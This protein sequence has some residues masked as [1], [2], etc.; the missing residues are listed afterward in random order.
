MA[1]LNYN[2]KLV[3]NLFINYFNLNF[4]LK[5]KNLKKITF[6][7]KIKEIYKTIFNVY[8]L[9]RKSYI[10]T[11]N[12]IYLYKLNLIKNMIFSN[13]SYK[14]FTSK[15]KFRYYKYIGKKLT[16]IKRFRNRSFNNII[17]SLPYI[18]YALNKVTIILYVY[19]R[20][21]IY[22]INK[23]HKLNKIFLHLS[24]KNILNNKV[25]LK[26]L[27]LFK[28]QH[29]KFIDR[30][31][32]N[33]IVSKFLIKKI[34]NK[35]I[36]NNLFKLKNYF[37]MLFLY[38]NNNIIKNIN[39]N[40]YII[41]SLKKIMNKNLKKVFLYKY[42]VSNIYINNF[43]F[44][45]NSLS[46]LKSKL[47]DIYN[48]K[49]D[50]KIINLKYLFL[51]NNIFVH[52][53]IKKL[54]DRKKKVLTVIRSGIS[55]VKVG[56][57]NPI[58]L[59][60]KKEETREINIFK[61]LFNTLFNEDNYK[62]LLFKSLKEKYINIFKFLNNKHIIGVRIEAKG[63]LTKRLTASRSLYKSN[64]K[65]SL[66]NIYSTYNNISTNINKG[67]EKSNIKY[68]NSNSYNRNGSYGIKYWTSTY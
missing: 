5:H 7:I 23:L 9:L 28:I 27:K 42:Y 2:E 48:K 33:G 11:P 22:Y 60:S 65:G 50:I 6:L 51:E 24:D 3:Y 36:F 39:Y 41:N 59:I 67:F 46:N 55:L 64:Y 40:L 15:K 49:I 44:N 34:N 53:I 19:N 16:N 4:E 29:P 61:N 47:Y 68:I 54:N 58:L 32:K 25:K 17:I 43:K 14:L 31:T 56:I 13:L 38:K 1:I 45:N 18:K 8:D 37:R 12:L 62:S 57:I 30:Y 10:N 35:N 26:L 21:K 20:E 66:K 52:G 63:R